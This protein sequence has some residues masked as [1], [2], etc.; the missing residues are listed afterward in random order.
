MLI[1]IQ[2]ILTSDRD[3]DPLN[4]DL[5]KK[6][7]YDLAETKRFSNLVEYFNLEKITGLK[8]HKCKEFKPLRAHHCSVCN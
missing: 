7:S 4:E 8:C 6:F 1:I 2:K 5:V 3:L